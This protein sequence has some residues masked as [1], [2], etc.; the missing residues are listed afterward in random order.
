M[1]AV[2]FFEF[3]NSDHFNAELA[4][5]LIVITVMHVQKATS[6]LLSTALL[7]K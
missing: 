2:L 5:T 6:I 3:I 1:A 4:T 7:F